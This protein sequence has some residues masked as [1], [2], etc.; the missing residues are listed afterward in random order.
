MKL[1]INELINYEIIHHYDENSGDEIKSTGNNFYIKVNGKECLFSIPGQSRFLM[2]FRIFRRFLRYDKSNAV[3]NWNRDGI[4]VLFQWKIYFFDLNN[5]E[6]IYIN[7][8]KQCRN[9]LHGGIAVTSKTIC[10]GEYGHNPNREP[11]PIWTSNDDGRSFSIAKELVEQKIKHIHGIY[12]DKFNESLWIV[13]GDFDGECYV[14]ESHDSSFMK[15]NW[16]GDGSQKWR[17]VSLFFK[18]NEIIWVM[19]SPIQK[20]YLQIFNREKKTIQQGQYFP[21][22]VWY[23]KQFKEG[24][25]I[26]QTTVEIGDEVKTRFS[27]VFYSENLIDWEEVYRFKK[28]ILPMPYF[29]FGVVAFADGIQSKEDFVLFGEA[30]KNMDGRSAKASLHK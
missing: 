6:L 19:D 29:K 12:A 26:L 18:P 24:D 3:F 1:K 20:A 5:E 21:G 9:V 10:F 8:L 25:A 16:Y 27:K 15:L 7:N 13:T 22:P 2:K 17:P 14:I 23:S 30:L 4:V 11:V 28:D